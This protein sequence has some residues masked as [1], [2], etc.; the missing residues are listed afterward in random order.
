ML[1]SRQRQSGTV[2]E[3]PLLPTEFTHHDHHTT[4]GLNHPVDLLVH[5]P[6]KVQH[7][8]LVN[9]PKGVS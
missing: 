8:K 5:H 4:I 7:S 6:P 9:S 3:L 2:P 1:G